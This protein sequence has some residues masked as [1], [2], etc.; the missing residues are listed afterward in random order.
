MEHCSTTNRNGRAALLLLLAVLTASGSGCATQL[1]Y[2]PDEFAAAVYECDLARAIHNVCSGDLQPACAS[3]I[4]CGSTEEYGGGTNVEEDEEYYDEELSRPEPI[5]R[6]LARRRHYE[7]GPPPV[8][9]RPTT[10]SKFLPVPSRPV[11][12]QP[13]ELATPAERGN[14][15]IGFGP[16]WTFP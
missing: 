4:E 13:F 14:V 16:E 6:P 15:E 3:G 12:S 10:P 9:Y 7:V 5:I 11:F 2:L 8:T 1:Q